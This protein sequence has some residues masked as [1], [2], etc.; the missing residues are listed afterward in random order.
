ML[1]GKSDVVSAPVP[2]DHPALKRTE[3]G[4]KIGLELFNAP[5]SAHCNGRI[6]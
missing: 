2:S 6:A 3:G 5:Q 4:S 1:L